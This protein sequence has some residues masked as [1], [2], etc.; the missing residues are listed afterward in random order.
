MRVCISRMRHVTVR[1]RQVL[2]ACGQP[3]G[4]QLRLLPCVRVRCAYAFFLPR[5]AP[6]TLGTG[7]ARVRRMIECSRAFS[8][9]GARFDM[10]L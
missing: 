2:E 5:I 4:V 8:R 7:V 6:P 3:G 1:A 10:C 9:V